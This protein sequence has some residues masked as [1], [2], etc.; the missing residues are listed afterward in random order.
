MP[1]LLSR[2]SPASSLPSASCSSAVSDLSPTVSPRAAARLRNRPSSRPALQ[3]LLVLC[4]LQQ[5]PD[6]PRARAAAARADRAR[7]RRL[8]RRALRRPRRRAVRARR[9]RGRRGRGDVPVHAVGSSACSARARRTRSAGRPTRSTSGRPTRRATGSTCSGRARARAPRLAR[10][11]TRSSS[12]P[13]RTAARRPPGSSWLGH[14]VNDGATMPSAAVAGGDDAAVESYAAAARARQRRRG[15]AG[16][17]APPSRSSRQRGAG[18]RR[19]FRDVRASLLAATRG[20]DAAVADARRARARPRG[21]RAGRRGGGRRRRTPRSSRAHAIS[22]G[23]AT[24]M[25]DGGVE[26]ARARVRA[27]P[28]PPN[29]RD[30]TT[31]HTPRLV[32]AARRTLL[33]RRGIQARDASTDRRGARRRARR[34]RPVDHALDARVRE[35]TRD[36]PDV[37]PAASC[38]TTARAAV[39]RAERRARRAA[40]EH[41]VRDEEHERRR[42]L[43]ARARDGARDDEPAVARVEDDDPMQQEA[44]VAADLELR[45][46]EQHRPRREGATACAPMTPAASARPTCAARRG[47][48]H[49]RRR[50]ADERLRAR[51]QPAGRAVRGEMICPSSALLASAVLGSELSRRGS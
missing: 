37:E 40:A 39:A 2:F 28:F 9:A 43:L 36:T 27:P 6:P 21:R 7:G 22:R 26:A 38:P 5:P 34:A 29:V 1:R 51:L 16:G 13:T 23:R 31:R 32:V 19:A 4:T 49:L 41:P 20:L 35:D 50:V 46:T 25:R 12:T 42:A 30:V 14:L 45:R 15:R 33:R 8:A 44:P 47:A 18:G 10:G 3:R 11:A 48:R 24:P 17:A